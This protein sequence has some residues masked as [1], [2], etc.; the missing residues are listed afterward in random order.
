M[1]NT[2][3][4]SSTKDRP[5]DPRFG[6]AWDRLVARR[7]THPGG[8]GLQ[9]AWCATPL[10]PVV[11]AARPEGVCFL[12][13]SDRERLEGGQLTRLAERFGEA[14]LGGENEP[15]EVLR[16]EL[17]EYF[18]GRRR[19]FTVPLVCPGT[20]FQV[21]VWDTL[22]TIPYGQTRSYT[23]VAR[24]IG[25]GRAV[26]A[27]GHANGRNPISI[28]IPCHRVVNVGGRLGGYGGGL[29]RKERLIALEQGQ[30]VL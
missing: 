3:S 28:V 2:R 12:E 22:R 27:V 24:A 18:A 8:T 21:R 6:E 4:S 14:V 13:F 7:P 15:L 29:W 26:R 16:R 17:E 10:G 30:A 9:A 25:A 5:Q 1:L 19:V 11:A 23:E 20:P